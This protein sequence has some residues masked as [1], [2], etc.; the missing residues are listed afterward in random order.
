MSILKTAVMMIGEF[1]YDGIFF[2]ENVL[3]F[4]EIT[5]MF[6]IFFLIIMCIIIVN[7]M[8][9]LAVDDIQQVR[10]E[11]GLKKAALQVKI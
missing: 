9:G 4:P 2:G 3:Q 7:L 5:I 8:V 6:F 11:A 1:E 10:E